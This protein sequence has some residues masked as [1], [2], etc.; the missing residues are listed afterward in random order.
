M[1]GITLAQAKAKLAE[2]MAADTAVATNQSYNI[3]GRTLTRADAVEIRR[4]IDYWN[5]WVVTL[6]KF[7]NGRTGPSLVGGTP[8]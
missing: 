2:W 7:P 1:A 4:N 5:N 3:A 8:L 6:D